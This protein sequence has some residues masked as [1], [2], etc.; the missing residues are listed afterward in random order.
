MVTAESIYDE[1]NIAPTDLGKKVVPASVRDPEEQRQLS[2]EHIRVRILPGAMS[3]VDVPLLKAS[4]GYTLPFPDNVVLRKY[5]TL[6]TVQVA[7]VN[8]SMQ[9][10]Y[11]EAVKSYARAEIYKQVASQ[12]KGYD[13]DSDTDRKTADAQLLKL[14]SS[15]DD[16]LIGDPESAGSGRNRNSGRA[17]TTTVD[18]NFSF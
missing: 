14:L 4:R 18:N 3:E 16:I 13:E 12:S 6:D 5:P 2:I 15:V 8:S 11:D 7:N 9:T 17:R 1:A 10:L